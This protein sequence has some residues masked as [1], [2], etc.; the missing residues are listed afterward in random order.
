[1]PTTLAQ[2]WAFH[3]AP[4]AFRKLTPPPIIM[5]LHR[6][7]LKSLTDGEVEFTL[8]FGP[9]PL[10]WIA[11]HE[12]GPTETSFIDRQISS[13]PLKYWEH[14]HIFREVEG[15]VELVDHIT[16]AHKSRLPLGLFTQLV[17]HPIFLR[18]LFLYRH[19]RTRLALRAASK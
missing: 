11:Q 4:N 7:E 2:M 15:G 12:P 5:Q 13:G 6:N 18:I 3:A 8:W 17:F 14:Q 19:I 1:M 10:R 16:Y 9:V